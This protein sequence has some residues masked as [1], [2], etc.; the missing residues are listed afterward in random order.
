[1]AGFIFISTLVSVY[2]SLF[3]MEPVKRPE[4]I[5]NRTPLVKEVK[6]TVTNTPKEEVTKVK[7]VTVIQETNPI[8]VEKGKKIYLST[9]IKC[10]NKDP[11]VK[12]AIG[13]ELVDAPL[14]IM[15]YKVANGKYPKDLP[16]GFVPKRKTNQMIKQP[17]HLKDVP[18]LHAY[19]QSL[20]K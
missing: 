13:P 6:T 18:S 4:M 16:S 8:D 9:C 17:Q 3:F 19:I 10:H 5:I 1:M 7:P 11:N 2:L 15:S 20:K 12:G 14:E